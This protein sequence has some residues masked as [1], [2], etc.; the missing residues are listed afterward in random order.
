[1]EWE[2]IP[3][4]ITV[5]MATQVAPKT[6]ITICAWVTSQHDSPQKSGQV[7]RPLASCHSY[8]KLGKTPKEKH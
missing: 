1:M 8:L 7:K 5:F 3:S 2:K 4:N 6:D